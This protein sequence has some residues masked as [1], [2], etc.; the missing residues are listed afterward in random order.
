MIFSQA[1]GQ[2][3]TKVYIWDMELDT[4]QFFDFESGHGEQDDGE[5]DDAELS[6]VERFVDRND[7]LAALSKLFLLNR[8]FHSALAHYKSLS[9]G[10]AFE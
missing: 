8:I 6:D 5:T 4:V 1:D 2:P 3:D 10:S 7:C 9:S